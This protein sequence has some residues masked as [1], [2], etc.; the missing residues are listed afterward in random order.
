MNIS[1]VVGII[2]RSIIIVVVVVVI[3]YPRRWFLVPL[4]VLC[5]GRGNRIRSLPQYRV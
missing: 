3:I 5:F 1:I 4:P 2:I